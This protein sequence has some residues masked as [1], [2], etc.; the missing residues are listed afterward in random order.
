MTPLKHGSHVLA[1]LMIA[2]FTYAYIRISF[3]NYTAFDTGIDLASYVEAL[4]NLSQGR[5]P[6][7]SFKG[8]VLWGDHGHFILT[9]IAPFFK[10][11]P[12]ARTILAVQVVVVTTAGWALY[13]CATRLLK[14]QL[15][16]LTLLYAY[17]AF[18]G[19][20]YALDFDFHPSVLTGAAIIWML[21]AWQGRHWKLYWLTL[22]LAL[23]TREDAPTI[24]FMIGA[25][26]LFRRQ[27]KVGSVTMLVS[28]VY[29]LMVV[30][31]IMP[32]WSPSSLPLTYLDADDKDPYNVIRGFFVYPDAIIGNMINSPIKIRTMHI[33]VQSFSYFPLLSPFFYLAAAPIFYARFA[34]SSDYR[35]VIDNHSN[36]NILPILVFAALLGMASLLRLLQTE[37]SPVRR[38]IVIISITVALI[39]GVQLTA[40]RDDKAPLARW[41]WGESPVAG[42][43]DFQ[44]LQASFANVVVQ[45]PTAEPLATTSGIASHLSQYHPIDLYPDIK[46]STNWLL[47]SAASNP[48]PLSR[49][50]LKHDIRLL[51]ADP[52]W[53]VA[54]QA[55]ELVLFKRVV[56]TR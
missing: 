21:Y 38:F 50:V 48:W 28:A 13:R 46:P 56:A 8:Q 10:I 47:L 17:L 32:M 33:L 29:F 3:A 45:I 6:W 49:D 44:S 34:S 31:I 7:S 16:S 14:S 37:R 15:L 4:H 2:A 52:D 36:A 27:W 23:I 30:Y 55:E 24:T 53:E 5:L 40:W 19:I 54:A 1:W 18:I 42:P 51:S 41:W 9:L 35:W 11:F 43:V 25:Y 22:G 39:V 12:D 26:L 20:Q